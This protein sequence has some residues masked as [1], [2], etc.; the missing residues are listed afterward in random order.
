MPTGDGASQQCHLQA[1]PQ[2]IPRPAGTQC[3]K[4]MGRSSSTIPNYGP[5]GRPEIQLFPANKIR[6]ITLHLC[7]HFPG[8][9]SVLMAIGLRINKLDGKIIM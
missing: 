7:L 3:T 5:F 1:D 9:Q 4:A 2:S 8:V 6:K